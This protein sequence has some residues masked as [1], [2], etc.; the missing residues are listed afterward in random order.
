MYLP[1]WRFNHADMNLII[2]C[3]LFGPVIS[4]VRQIK[5]TDIKI[6]RYETYQKMSYRN[7]MQL[8]SPHGVQNLSV[9]LM[10]GRDQKG[11]LTSEI[12]IDYSGKWL[13]EQW[14]SLESWYN[15][16]PFFFHYS[17]AVKAI[18]EERPRYLFD[19]ALA[20]NRWA[21][22][23]L[24]WN[25]AL[26]FTESWINAYQQPGETTD[27]RNRILPRNRQSFATKTY[28]QV[29][30]DRFEGNLSILDL[31]FNMGPQSRTYLLNQV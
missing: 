28:Q 8:L 29:F 26:D 23:Q 2:E 22:Q 21:L 9:P 20:S 5:C 18:F 3:Q 30:G 15:R 17:S 1:V 27:L 13:A 11:R 24:G 10:G 7:R 4:F 14:R 31:L 19:L 25:G 16:S 12:E 6:E